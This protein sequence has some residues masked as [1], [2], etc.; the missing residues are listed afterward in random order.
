MNAPAA[1]ALLAQTGPR[2]RFVRYAASMAFGLAFAGLASLTQL[3]DRTEADLRDLALR[4]AAA[5]SRF[6]KVAVIDVDEDSMRALEPQLGAWPYPRQVYALVSAYLARAGAKA[7]AYDVLFAES[8]E[9]DEAFAEAIRERPV[10]LAAAALPNSMERSSAYRER[11]R[12]LAWPVPGD[13]PRRHWPDLTLPVESLGATRVG[14]V[15]LQPDPDGLVRRLPLFHDVGGAVVPALS[16]AALHAA[17]DVPHVATEPGAVRVGARRWPVNAG[18]EAVLRFPATTQGLDIIPFHQVVLATLGRPGGERIAAR[19]AGRTVVLGS[20]A[21][22]LGDYVQTPAGRLQGVA[23]TAM[24]VE[25]LDRGDVLAPPAW[26]PNLLLVAIALVVPA[27][28]FHRRLGNLRYFPWV[29]APAA[30]VLVGAVALFF[31]L[32]GQQATLLFPMLVTLAGL[33]ADLFGRVVALQRIRQELGAEKLAAERA[34]ELKGQFMSY[35]THELRTPMTA[36]LGFNRRMADEAL[37]PAERS[38]YAEIVDKNSRHLLTLINNILDGAK[39][40]AGQMRIAPAPSSVRD[41]AED[42]VL[43]LAPLAE[44]KGI[45]VRQRGAEALPALLDVDPLRLKQVLLNLAGNA[46]KFTEAG[47]V[48]LAFAWRDG[49]LVV[50]VED[51]GPGMDAA[52]LERI[53]VPFQQAHERVAQRHGG[54]GLGLTISRQLC[55][56]M[57]GSLTARSTPGT[58]S[59]FTAEVAAPLVQEPA[60]TPAPAVAVPALPA[61]PAVGRVLLADDSEDIRDLVSFYLSEA[62]YEV[63]MAV[64]GADALEAVRRDPP[65]AVLTDLEMPRMNGVELARALRAEGYPGPILLLTAHPEGPETERALAAGCT[66]YVA[67]PV[68]PEMLKTTLKTTMATQMENP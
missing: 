8:R 49:R 58:G 66:G 23:V 67:K 7:L 28:A 2:A 55:V 4:F 10:A 47:A 48:T 31:L 53:F 20:S 63:S 57:G 65:D 62:G 27:L 61:T 52:Q 33:F 35:M 29:S 43:S 41:L 1:W 40:D 22:R 64:D 26:G 60:P 16:L 18:G 17:E 51:T 39:L 30:V 11:L 3:Y 68:D 36:I 13:M 44:G 45:A 50:D 46:V 56:L 5:D 37:A 25:L 19:V 6:E 9:G 59:T 21:E 24:A 14:V 42:V 32:R 34:A 12:A 38:R 54:T 15:T